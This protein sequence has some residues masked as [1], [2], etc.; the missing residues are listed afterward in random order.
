MKK[1]SENNFS[2]NKLFYTQKINRMN[3]TKATIIFTI[4]FIFALKSNAQVNLITNGS[5]ES[6][7][8]ACPTTSPNGQ[9]TQVS[10]GWYPGNF[11]TA[12]GQSP[13]VDL[14]CGEP[15]YLNCLPGP[16]PNVGSN[17]VSY[18]GLHTRIYSPSYN[19]SIY[20][21]LATPLTTGAVY[22]ISFDLMNCQSGLFT[23]GQSNFAVYTNIDTLVP[24]CPSTNPSVN[25]VGFVPFDSISNVSWKRH[26][27][28]FVAPS[29]SNV[30]AFSGDSCNVSEIYFYLDSVVLVKE[31]EQSLSEI[32]NAV[33]FTIVPNPFSTQTV[34]KT[35]N[36][37]NNAT[38]TVDNIFGR[39]V[40]QMDN[41]SGQSIVFERDNLP[42]GL[43]LIRIM[44]NSKVISTNKIVIT[45]N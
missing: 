21:I 12:L 22:T 1:K 9:F 34:L 41:I 2:T 33:K 13:D 25:E 8:G 19:E 4:I 17:G 45:D 43:Y 15:N 44:Q 10:G 6:F 16:V 24:A 3:R 42:S 23:S 35:E 31:A 26:S 32:T 40:K 7:T 37:L 14:Y 27:F 39:T 30:I 18:I 38:I 29:N 20:Q 11:I 36:S 28:S 5:F